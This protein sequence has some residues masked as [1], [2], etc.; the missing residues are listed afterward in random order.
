M[1]LTCDIIHVITSFNCDIFYLVSSV[2]ESLSLLIQSL[3]LI[4]FIKI[5]QKDYM[6]EWV[7]LPLYGSLY[8]DYLF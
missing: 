7:Q 4:S 8:D 5:Y 1:G 2:L 6:I 3:Y